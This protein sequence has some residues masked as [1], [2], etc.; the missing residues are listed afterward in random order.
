MDALIVSLSRDRLYRDIKQ[1]NILIESS[2]D[3]PHVRIIDFGCGTFLSQGKYIT[4]Q[5]RLYFLQSWIGGLLC[6]VAVSVLYLYPSP[7]NFYLCVGIVG[8]DLCTSPD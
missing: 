7:I 1:D 5:G 8:T 3:V 4:G 6:V 2:S